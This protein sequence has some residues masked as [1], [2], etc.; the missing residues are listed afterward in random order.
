MGYFT[1]EEIKA[2]KSSLADI[3]GIGINIG[4]YNSNDEQKG[5][6]FDK[7][8]LWR[9]I[10][11]IISALYIQRLSEGKMFLHDGDGNNYQVVA[12]GKKEVESV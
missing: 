9:V 7:A 1:K 5:T 6:F 11:R 8:K 3:S 2:V 4:R 10:E 12:V